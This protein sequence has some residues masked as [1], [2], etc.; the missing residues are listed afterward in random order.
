M[1]RGQLKPSI[2]PLVVNG[3]FLRATPTGLARVARSLLEA[4]LTAGLPAEVVAPPGIPDPLISRHTRS[5]SGG[6]GDRLWE[7]TVL[8]AVARRRRVLSLTNTAPIAGRNVMWVHDL[9]PLVGPQ[10]F[11]RSMRLYGELV[12]HA[13]RRAERVFTVSEQI[14][15]EL[16]SAGVKGPIGVVR[17]AVDPGLVAPGPAETAAALKRLGV[18]EPYLL[19][20]GWTDPRKD[21]LTAVA[22]HLRVAKSRP[23][24]LVLVGLPRPIFTAVDLPDSDTIH[25]VGYVDDSDLRALLAGAA[26]LLYPS[27]YEGFGL[28]PIEAWQCGTP[29][30]VSDIPSV[31]EA[32]QNRAVYVPTGDVAAWAEAME[33][34]LEG[35][36][37]T[38]E[39]V[40]WSWSDAAEQLLA[41]LRT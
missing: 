14:R 25:V 4:G 34:A 18:H 3:R 15:E 5:F 10:W 28:P 22:A 26:A 23:H 13:A 9:A 32:T 21:A 33:A 36:I 38:P 35:H 6:L 41:I 20:V 30:I 12:L 29:A 8:P 39:P 37:P 19:I 27:H 2:E 16:V 40:Q 1:I 7:Q 17:S 31:R 11:T 24:Q